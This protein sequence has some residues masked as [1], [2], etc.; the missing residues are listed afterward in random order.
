MEGSLLCALS[1]LFSYIRIPEVLFYRYSNVFLISTATLCESH[2]SYANCML[3]NNISV[4]GEL[5]QSSRI[6]VIGLGNVKS[7]P[8]ENGKHKVNVRVNNEQKQ[9]GLSV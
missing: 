9:N 7:S 1:I 8:T 5:R 2:S 6:L 3:T 4:E